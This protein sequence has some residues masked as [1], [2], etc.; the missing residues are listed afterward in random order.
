MNLQKPINTTAFVG[1]STTE[2]TNGFSTKTE[3]NAFCSIRRIFD[4]TGRIEN[5]IRNTFGKKK[6]HFQSPKVLPKTSL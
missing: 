6:S 5:A 4:R 1:V 2:K 3:R